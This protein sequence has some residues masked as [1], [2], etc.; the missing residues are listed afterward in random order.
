MEIK[1]FSEI[2]KHFLEKLS[3]PKSYSTSKYSF[4]K[5]FQHA[6]SYA[7]IGD[8]NKLI[9]NYIHLPLA[10][11]KAIYTIKSIVRKPK[12]TNTKFKDVVF[13]DPGRLF[14][15]AEHNYKSVYFD[16]FKECF[17]E[18]NVTTI[19]K[20]KNKHLKA[21]YCLQDFNRN[22]PKLDETEMSML[23]EIKA[24]SL[25]SRKS[26]Q[27]TDAEVEYINSA[28]HIFFED[29]RFYYQLF[30]NNKPKAVFFICHYHNEG[31]IA[32][33]QSLDIKCIEMQHGL[34]AANDLYYVY[35]DIFQ[36][37]VKHAFFPD[38]IMVY[39]NYWRKVLLEG[40]E[41]EDSQIVVAGDYLARN[42]QSDQKKFNKENILLICAQ[43]MLFKEYVEYAKK[44][45]PVLK[46]HSTWKAMIKLHPLENAKHE[47]ATLT[48]LGYEIVDLEYTLDELLQ[49]SKIQI[50]IYSTTFYDAIGFEVMNFS[51]QNYG[52]SSDYAAD[53]IKEGVAEPLSIADDPIAIYLEKQSHGFNYMD[54]S[55]I[56]GTFNEQLVLSSI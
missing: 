5:I 29:F 26:G 55:M 11:Q 30:K 41:F 9:K 8:K 24:V 2:N 38:K 18:D 49:R 50:S 22:L 35:N 56:Y 34:I 27:F 47:Y 21:D 37:A 20:S 44:L 43:K 32:A 40:C 23:T 10:L 48:S 15:I 36:D 28:L 13:I 53:M 6:L 12:T 25:T 45:A 33:L 19:L 3:S 42:Q 31:L 17:G 51:L 46:Q 1:P 7:L 54:R 52:T 39:G 16:K 14:K 4:L